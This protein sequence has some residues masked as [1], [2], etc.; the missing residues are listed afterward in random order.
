MDLKSESWLHP[1]FESFRESVISGRSPSSLIISGDSGLGTAALA[2]DCARFYLCHERNS[3]QEEQ[4]HCRSCGLFSDL[5]TGSHPD[6][7]ILCSSG[8]ASE[9]GEDLTYSFSDLFNDCGT[10]L[11]NDDNFSFDTAPASKQVKVDGVRRLNEWIFEGSA[12]GHGKVAIVSNAHTMNESA[13]NAMLKTFEEP[14]D[15]T[16]IILLTKNLE[17]LPATIV[18]RAVKYQIPYVQED[19]ALKYLRQNLA[20]SA[21]DESLKI[22]LALSCNSPYKALNFFK[23]GLF[24]I[25]N[26]FVTGIC[27]CLQKKQY[28][29]CAINALMTLPNELKAVVLQEFIVEL[30]KYKAGVSLKTLPVLQSHQA[31]LLAKIKAESLFEVYSELPGLYDNDRTLVIKAP[32]SMLRSWLYRLVTI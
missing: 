30:L 19:T 7:L 15:R 22:C 31:D 4:H 14:A 3:F 11:Y 24:D 8:A 18:S 12:L 9:K 32:V 27:G 21:Q 28:D 5:S 29:N 26:Q 20:D 10:S 17:S 23:A 2:L 13:A 25:V 1:F 16:L 6:L